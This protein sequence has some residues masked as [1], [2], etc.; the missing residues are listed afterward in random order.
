MGTRQYSVP[1]KFLFSRRT[2]VLWEDKEPLR[3]EV[4]LVQDGADEGGES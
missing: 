4:H 1:A 3:W 2:S